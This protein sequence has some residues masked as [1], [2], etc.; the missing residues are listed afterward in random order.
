MVEVCI[1]TIS[2]QNLQQCGCQTGNKL[3]ENKKHIKKK[4][5]KIP[6]R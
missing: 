4:R 3:K 5:L 2:F 6:K 1:G